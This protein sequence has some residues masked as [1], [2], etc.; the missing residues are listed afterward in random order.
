MQNAME[1][2]ERK[3]FSDEKPTVFLHSLFRENKAQIG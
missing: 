1:Q 2:N 3:L